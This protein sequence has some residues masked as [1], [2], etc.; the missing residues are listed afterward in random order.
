MLS[1]MPKCSHTFWSLS[2]GS[3][4]PKSGWEVALRQQQ[5]WLGWIIKQ[6]TVT[7]R[8]L[9]LFSC[10]SGAKIWAL[11][12]AAGVRLAKKYQK[13][14]APAKW[15]LMRESDHAGGGVLALIVFLGMKFKWVISRVATHT[16]EKKLISESRRE[17]QDVCVGS[18]G[19][20]TRVGLSH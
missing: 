10:R 6:V 13:K 3:V 11:P 7:L 12:R 17:K 1:L 20:R 9:Q 19:A 4:R 8:A 2:L 18:L 14:S 5:Q 16:R 15:D